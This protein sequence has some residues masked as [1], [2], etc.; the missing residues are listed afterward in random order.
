MAFLYQFATASRGAEL[1]S[2]PEEVK[3]SV[4][5]LGGALSA[6]AI[7]GALAPRRVQD[8]RVSG[9]DMR[10]LL[11]ALGSVRRLAEIVDDALQWET[12][13]TPFVQESTGISLVDGKARILT[14][15]RSSAFREAG[16]WTDAELQD[17]ELLVASDPRLQK[18]FD[19]MEV[20][21]ASLSDYFSKAAGFP[22]LALVLLVAAIAFLCLGVK[23]D[24]NMG[25][26][27]SSGD[28]VNSVGGVTPPS[29][30]D[31]QGLPLFKLDK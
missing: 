22:I 7:A 8:G 5:E 24:P 15:L 27:G 14:F 28:A 11:K 30:S 31:L 2:A 4:M 3:R 10:P 13:F 25:G 12:V 1:Q 19:R 16:D 21:R 18:V 20:V 23:L 6:D 17:A 9:G 29:L 26:A